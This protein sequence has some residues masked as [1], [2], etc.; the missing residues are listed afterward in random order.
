[1]AKPDKPA[2]E[3]RHATALDDAGVDRKRL[4]EVSEE[5]HDES[6]R[7]A[8]ILG[9]AWLD[10]GLRSLLQAYLLPGS[11][12]EDSDLFGPNGALGTFS[13]RISLAQRLGLISED[14]KVALEVVRKLRN[15]FAHQVETP[16]LTEQ[17]LRD[18]ISNIPPY[19]VPG[20]MLW[21]T[22]QT[23]WYGSERSPRV[24]L[25]ST[26]TMLV[27]ML[28][29]SVSAVRRVAIQGGLGS[30]LSAHHGPR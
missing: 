25:R 6:D 10:E 26:I 9:A 30:T 22:Y 13:A 4:E 19:F 5:L 15:K 14:F 24:T 18:L 11:A 3:K 20:T 27:A 7:A 21:E 16:Q 28:L 23:K 8:I 29:S 2:A 1:M 12:K 17:S